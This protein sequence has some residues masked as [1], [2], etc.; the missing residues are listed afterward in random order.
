MH[1]VRAEVA[2]CYANSDHISFR[3][4]YAVTLTGDVGR[5][6]P[7]AVRKILFAVAELA[8]VDGARP[9]SR[10]MFPGLQ[11]LKADQSG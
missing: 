10:R 6:S 4:G 1:P 8:I 7:M 5:P 3:L 9:D 2:G 11:Y